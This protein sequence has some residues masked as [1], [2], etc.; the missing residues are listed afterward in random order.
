MNQTKTPIPDITNVGDLFLRKDGKVY[1]KKEKEV[2][3]HGRFEMDG[4]WKP[5]AKSTFQSVVGPLLQLHKSW[6]DYR[7]SRK[8]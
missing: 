1:Q 2:E 7:Q 8:K 4:T 5:N 6:L 3:F